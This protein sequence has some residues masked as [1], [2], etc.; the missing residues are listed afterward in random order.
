MSTPNTTTAKL[1]LKALVCDDSKVNRQ[2]MAKNLTKILQGKFDLKISEA[3]SGQEAVC[4]FNDEKLPS[5]DFVIM[6][7][8]MKDYEDE[9]IICAQYLRNCLKYDGMIF[10][11]STKQ[12]LPY[13]KSGQKLNDIF[14]GYLPKPFEAG[15]LGAFFLKALENV[16]LGKFKSEPFKEMS[17]I[18]YANCLLGKG[19]QNQGQISIALCGSPGS[20]VSPISTQ[21]HSLKLEPAKVRGVKQAE[22]DNQAIPV[23]K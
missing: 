14:T 17:F 4:K 21:L 8:E 13:E 1:P 23:A 19:V 16:L 6:D 11:W 9:G 7:V 15:F 5:F 3:S 22:V 20:E 2:L 18:D 10:M 12:L